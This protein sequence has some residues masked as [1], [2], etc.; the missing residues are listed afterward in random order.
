MQERDWLQYI[1]D[2]TYDRDGYHTA[3]DLGELVDE[4]YDVAKDALNGKESPYPANTPEDAPYNASQMINRIK[5]L[6]VHQ[7][8]NRK[9]LAKYFKDICRLQIARFRLANWRDL[10]LKKIDILKTLSIQETKTISELQTK[11]SIVTKE[12]DNLL[13]YRPTQSGV[14]MKSFSFGAIVVFIALLIGWAISLVIV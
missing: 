4:I 10:C 5:Y 11:L 8:L 3:K 14:D 1:K 9:Q 7:D 2:I 13:V 12:R 6:E